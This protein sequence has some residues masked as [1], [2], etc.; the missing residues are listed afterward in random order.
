MILF[1]E[2][3]A[4]TNRYQSFAELTDVNASEGQR[5]GLPGSYQALRCWQA[6][7]ER[8]PVV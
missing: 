4:G 2:P 6:S 8:P 3:V 1:G 7:P 5:V